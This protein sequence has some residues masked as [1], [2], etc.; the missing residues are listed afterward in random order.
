MFPSRLPRA[1]RLGLFGLAALI[2]LVLCLAPSRDL[3][4]TATGDRFEHTAAWFVLTITGYVLAPKRGIAIP[5][6]ALAFGGVIEILQGTV[7]T[8]RHSDPADFVADSVGVALAV[9]VFF[10]VRR[11]WRT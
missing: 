1:L 3:P 9:L 4:D 2:L 10:I 8:G 11:V 6:F 5:I 7:G